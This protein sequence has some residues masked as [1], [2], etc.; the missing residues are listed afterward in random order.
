MRKTPREQCRCPAFPRVPPGAPTRLQRS[1]GPAAQSQHGIVEVTGSIP[2][3]ST[4]KVKGL[5]DQ[6]AKPLF[7]AEAPRKN[8]D[9]FRRVLDIPRSY[10]RQ[11]IIIVPIT[12]PLTHKGSIISASRAKPRRTKTQA[13]RL[14]SLGVA[15][16]VNHRAAI[17]RSSL[18]N[19]SSNPSIILVSNWLA[20]VSL[21]AMASAVLPSDTPPQRLQPQHR[22][23][24]LRRLHRLSPR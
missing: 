1:A 9:R 12:S 24:L 10:G 23:D 17:C 4:N 8:G 16:P 2:V 20:A 22:C 11:L 6:T 18:S 19:Q 14:P 15:A 7:V 21:R 13:Y 3:G 5:T